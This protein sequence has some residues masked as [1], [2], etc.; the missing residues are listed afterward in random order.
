MKK[1]NKE[2]VNQDVIEVVVYK[3]VN[4]KVFLETLNFQSITHS[5]NTYKR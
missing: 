4:I 2:C 1:S 5:T 3:K